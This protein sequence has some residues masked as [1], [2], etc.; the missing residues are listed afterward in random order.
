MV[1]RLGDIR[2]DAGM[3]SVQVRQHEQQGNGRVNMCLQ[4]QAWQSFHGDQTKI[5]ELRARARDLQ[6]SARCMT[7]IRV[8]LFRR[9]VLLPCWV[10]AAG[11]NS[12]E[13]ESEYHEGRHA[14]ISLMSDIA[15]RRLLLLPPCPLLMLLHLRP[16]PHL[17][18]SLL[19]HISA[20]PVLGIRLHHPGLRGG[21]GGGGF[22]CETLL[23]AEI[24]LLTGSQAGVCRR[25]REFSKFDES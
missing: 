14:W 22:S 9:P 21:G 11:S 12:K 1:E 17:H 15:V 6:R 2:G 7:C 20:D 5:D 4:L 18:P 3:T 19:V 25:Y 13:E 24:E 8:L 23:G 16:P 10:D